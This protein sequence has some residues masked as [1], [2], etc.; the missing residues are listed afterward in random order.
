MLV[1][2]IPI[3]KSLLLVRSKTPSKIYIILEVFAH[4]MLTWVC[5]ALTKLEVFSF[6]Y[7]ILV[8]NLLVNKIV[9]MH[10]G[11]GAKN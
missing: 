8:I 11:W 7:M 9:D 10:V 4:Y 6:K 3:K 1:L 2:D 5:S